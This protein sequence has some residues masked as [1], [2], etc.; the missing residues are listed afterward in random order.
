[1]GSSSWLWMLVVA[2]LG[3]ATE[4]PWWSIGA[5]TMK[6]ISSTSMTSTSGVT[7]M[8]ARWSNG[9]PDWRWNAICDQDTAALG[10]V[11]LRQIDELQREVLHSGA[12]LADFPHEVVVENH[13]GDC[14]GETRR[15]VHERAGDAGSDGGDRGG[16]RQADRAE[17]LHDAPHRAEE[18]DEGT[19][20]GRRR[21]K[22][23]VPGQAR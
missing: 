15:G 16:A 19:R 2:V 9:S 23:H 22:G 17:R 7:L 18:A 12:L 5:V 14:G 4:M 21:E 10:E 3:R 11:P 6:M 8:S 1:M 13:R 20:R